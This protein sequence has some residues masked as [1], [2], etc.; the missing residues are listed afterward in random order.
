MSE[1]AKRSPLDLITAEG[2][3]D[4]A[5][6]ELCALADLPDAALVRVLGL[7]QFHIDGHL[8]ALFEAK[9]YLGGEAVERMDR[10][11]KWTMHA[12][13]VEVRAPSP[14]AGTV[15][16]DAV[17]LERILDE[18]IEQGVLDRAAKG[19]AVRQEIVLKVDKRGVDALLKIGGEVAARI[20][21]ARSIKPPMD[22][23]RKVQ[24]R[25]D[26]RQL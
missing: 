22:G 12:E 1:V 8:S 25:V 19:R 24:V 17:L 11:G 23:A 13:G 2:V 4:P 9:R 7:I 5:T 14:T 16:W 26:P 15:E 21:A 6:G 10:G 3:V 20:N 18:L